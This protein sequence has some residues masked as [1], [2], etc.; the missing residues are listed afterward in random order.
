MGGG[1]WSE[2]GWAVGEMVLRSSRAM[3][4]LLG[5]NRLRVVRRAL[6]DW[7]LGT[8]V[9]WGCSD[10]RDKKRWSV[11][12]LLS[13]AREAMV[14]RLGRR[15][16]YGAYRRGKCSSQ[17]W[18]YR[19][20]CKRGETLLRRV[21]RVVGRAS[22]TDKRRTDGEEVGPG[23]RLG[24]G[25][26]RRCRGFWSS[27]LAPLLEELR[28]WSSR[29][30]VTRRVKLGFMGRAGT[31]GEKRCRHVRRRCVPGQGGAQRVSKPLGAARECGWLPSRC[32][33]CR[34]SRRAEA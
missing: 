25:S 10:S 4:Q 22:A 31:A 28:C 15:E 14:S 23:R 17:V 29:R 7:W 34:C 26:R 18:G 27:G 32:E 8:G 2:V 9:R 6:G 24:C 5:R 11:G 12:G 33:G 19:R 20:A 16:G 1:S 3:A 21:C 30:S 13:R